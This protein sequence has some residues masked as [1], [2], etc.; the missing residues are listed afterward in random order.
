V[1]HQLGQRHALQR[2]MTGM[3]IDHHI[4]MMIVMRGIE[5]RSVLGPE[6]S[7]PPSCLFWVAWF[8]Y[9]MAHV[10]PLAVE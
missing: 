2:E 4:A 5:H 10:V 1:G 6:P 9:C 3:R 8:E 7:P